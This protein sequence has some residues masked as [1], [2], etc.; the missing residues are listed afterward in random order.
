MPVRVPSVQWQIMARLLP[1]LF[2]LFACSLFWLGEHLKEILISAN[3]ETARR[4]SM[5]V[6]YAVEASMLEERT[7]QVWDR[8]VEKIP[9][10]EETQIEIVNTA[11]A[12]I[13][14]TDPT[15]QGTSRQLNDPLCATCHENSYGPAT[16]E[17][18]FIRDPRDTRHQV[19]AAPLRNTEDCLTCHLDDGQ[20][21]LG[22]VLV[23]RSLEPIYKQVRNIQVALAAVGGVSLILTILMTRLLLGRYLGRPLRRLVAGAR[24]IGAGDLQRTIDVPERTELAVLADTLNA[25]SARLAETVRQL[26]QQRDDFQTLYGLVDQLGRSI[27]PEERRR[28]AVELAGRIFNTE[29]VLVHATRHVGDTGSNGIVV[30]RGPAEIVVHDLPDDAEIAEAPLFYA[31]GLVKR[32]MEGELDDETEVREGVT[33]AYPLQRQGRRLGLILRPWRTGDLDPE[34]VRTLCK[35]L[36]ITL[37]FS[38]LQCE[39]VEQERLAAIGETAAGLAHWLKNTLNGLRAGQYVIDRAVEKEDPE[40][41]RTGWRVMKNSVRQVEKLTSDLLYCVKERVPERVPTD[42]NQVIRGVIEMLGEM[43][44]ERG[45][46][47]THDLDEGIGEESLERDSIHRMLL[48]LITN[49]IDACTESESGD[50]VVVRSLATR[51]EIVLTIEDNGIG[52]SSAALV[53]LSKRFFSTKASKGTGLGLAVVKKIAEEHGGTL[54]VESEVGRGSVFQIHLPRSAGADARPAR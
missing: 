22:M 52:M 41:L 34:M 10:G 33:V 9:R 1:L 16:S 42:P 29:C 24:A 8:V 46:R 48:N 23:R 35:H 30:F 25:S 19:L 28:R 2:L 26:E 6:V 31:S 47:L 50:L 20:K 12:V 49:A 17:T 43:A 44:V 3:L 39:F 18:A 13:F 11:G 27:L 54:E 21:K 15:Q 32:W 5:V 45:V 4:S 40:K 37:E 53:N 51:D 38:D 14:S 7:H 36:A